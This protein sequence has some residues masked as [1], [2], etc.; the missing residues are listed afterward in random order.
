[1]YPIEDIFEDFFKEYS[2]NQTV[3]L[4]APTGTG[5]STVLPLEIL[6]RY[7]EQGK[8]IMLEPRRLAARAVADRMSDL[9]NEKTGG[10]VGYSIRFETCKSAKT[11]L[12]VVTEGILTRMLLSDNELKDV[13]TIIFD[14]FHERS[15]NADLALALI[16]ECQAVLRPDLKIIVMSATIDTDKLSA[17]LSAPVV[18]ATAKSFDV[19]VFYEGCC[20]E[21]SAPQQVA[22]TILKALEKH[23]EGDI[24]A[25][26]PGEGEIKKCEEFLRKSVDKVL[27][28]PLYGMLPQK[29]QREA[30]LPDSSGRR[31][32][33]LATSI[34]ETSLTIEGVKIVVDSG[35][36]K[37]QEYNSDRA[38]SGLRTVRISFDMAEQRKGRAGRIS[39]GFCYRLWDL[40]AESRMSQNRRPE[41]EYADLTP[42]MLDLAKWGE[43]NPENLTWLTPPDKT[44]VRL[45]KELLKN[46][47]AVDDN[48]LITPLGNELSKIPTHPRIAK[49]LLK[50]KKMS[51]LP[52]AADIAAILD[53][54]DPLTSEYGTDINLRIEKLRQNRKESRH[55]KN[56]D[57]LE[58]YACQ[59]RKI[60]NVKEDND[61]FDCYD[62]GFLL[63]QAFPERIASAKLGNNAQFMLSNGTI[64]QTFREDTLAGENWLTVAS[65]NTKE[66]GIAKIFLASPLDPSMLRDMVTEKILT[67][68]NTKK[69]GLVSTRQL[70]LFNIIL[71]ETPVKP[72]NGEAEKI[73]IEAV[74]KEGETLLDF[75]DEVFNFLNR[76]LS[77]RIWGETDFPDVSSKTLIETAESWLLPYINGVTTVEKLK[78]TDIIQAV[79]Y[80]LLTSEQLT[81][82]EKFAPEVLTVPTGHK[83]KLK[84]F[85][86]GKQPVLSV[87]LQEVFQWQETPRVCGGKVPVLMQLLSPGFKPVQL[88]S[89][90]KSFWQNAYKEVR[91]ELKRRYPKHQWPEI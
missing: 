81:R 40:T 67:V 49:M 39:N 13:S 65:L 32:V 28:K 3:I 8:I 42:L 35:L 53:N 72:D 84:Y 41:I 66:N 54:R 11:R 25:F 14:E 56:L 31:R 80:S 77:L 30:I 19:K 76:I 4:T 88:T 71:Q 79:K 26:L 82:L 38:L 59:L 27:I 62:T 37:V 90:L 91:K 52:L 5:K 23:K 70:K 6:R 64:A 29:L 17:L 43:A 46:L 73:V 34:A 87:R 47:D 74:K 16:R 1:M 15:L 50:A 21:F 86:D 22:N 7:P 10:T 44:N 36:T 58:L 45:A 55:N 78:K 61:G 68:W 20:D 63:A 69:G 60:F 83:I 2:K 75:N 89:D 51:L 33:V 57:R 85:D 12:E 9:L 24:L 18:R 48:F